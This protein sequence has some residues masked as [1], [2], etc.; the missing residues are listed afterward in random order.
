M[1]L[2]TTS[3]WRRLWRA[4]QGVEF[5]TSCVPANRLK[6]RVSVVRFRPW[7]PFHNGYVVALAIGRNGGKNR[8][9]G[10]WQKDAY[11]QAPRFAIQ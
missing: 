5:M 9:R 3:D 2:E 10:L 8:L 1:L 7:P 4:L 6:I 11:K